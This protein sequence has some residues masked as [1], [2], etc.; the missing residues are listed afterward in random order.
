[1]LPEGTHLGFWTNIY[2]TVMIT[3]ENNHLNNN[4]RKD[5]ACIGFV[6]LHWDTTSNVMKYDKNSA[7]QGNKGCIFI[8]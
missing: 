8:S 7:Q 1:M 5:F 2:F 4:D 6:S 3:I